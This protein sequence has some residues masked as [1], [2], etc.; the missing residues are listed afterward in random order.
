MNQPNDTHPAHADRPPPLEIGQ[1][2]TLACLLE[3]SAPKPGNVHRGADFENLTFYDF[4]VSSVAIAPAIALATKGAVG[5]AVLE[6]VRATQ[7][8]VH[9]NTNLGTLLLLA[10]LAAVPR[11]AEL[12]DGVVDVLAHLTPEDSDCVY[13]AIRLS[14]PGGLGYVDRADVRQSAPTDLLAAM[15]AAA[16]RD[17]VARQYVSH[18]AEVL[19]LVVPWLTDGPRYGWSLV[20]CIVHTHVR[21]MSRVPDTLIERK[22]G[23]PVARQGSYHAA[24]VLDAGQPGDEAYHQALADLDFWLRADHHR[25]NPGTTADLVAAGLFAALRDGLLPY[26]PLGRKEQDA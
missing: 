10:P 6:A 1:C 19:D 3:V 23:S 13:Q 16:D 18:F 26:P 24:T 21:L 5:R 11:D 8:M 20:D 17:T 9:T 12:R 2:A 7:A 14:R 15:R 4:V 22:C 25:R